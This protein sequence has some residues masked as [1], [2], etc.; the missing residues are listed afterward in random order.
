[1]CCSTFPLLCAADGYVESHPQ[2]LTRPILPVGLLHIRFHDA[3]AGG[4]GARCISQ[5]VCHGAN[6]SSG[7]AKHATAAM[8]QESA[9]MAPYLPRTSTHGRLSR[10]SPNSD[11]YY[12][13]SPSA[14]RPVITDLRRAAAHFHCLRITE[15]ICC[16]T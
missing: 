11:G 12:V 14:H 1:M 13:E 3:P 2:V 4:H 8:K 15:E 9:G 7:L 16:S 6:R 5:K 10:D